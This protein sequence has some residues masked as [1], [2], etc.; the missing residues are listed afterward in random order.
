MRVRNRLTMPFRAVLFVML[1]SLLVVCITATTMGARGSTHNTFRTD[2]ASEPTYSTLCSPD[3]LWRSIRLRGGKRLDVLIDDSA[4]TKTLILKSDSGRALDTIERFDYRQ[5]LVVEH[6]FPQYTVCCVNDHPT[7]GS[8]GR[9][10]LLYGFVIDKQQRRVVF[11]DSTYTDVATD[12]PEGEI[13]SYLP[14]EGVAGD[15][16]RV[17]DIAAGFRAEYFPLPPL[18]GDS[19][20]SGIHVKRDKLV[21]VYGSTVKRGPR[22][23]KKVTFRRAGLPK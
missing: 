18:G 4:E 19:Y 21:V 6:D 17:V 15:R 23:S 22:R 7:P 12:R 16:I 10:A 9:G 8:P 2:Y 14:T 1:A 5:V 13:V 20:V 11:R 3:R